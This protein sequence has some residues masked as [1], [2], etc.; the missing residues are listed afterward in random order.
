MRLKWQ[1]NVSLTEPDS[2]ERFYLRDRSKFIK[3]GD[4]CKIH[5]GTRIF[6]MYSSNAASTFFELMSMEHQP[7]CKVKSMGSMLFSSMIPWGHKIFEM[8]LLICTG[9]MLR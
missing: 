8:H 9:P 1:Y 2:W 6:F 4:P 5:G 3:A 7:I